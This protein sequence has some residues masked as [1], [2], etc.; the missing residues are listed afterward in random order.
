MAAG[1]DDGSKRRRAPAA[2]IALR[3]PFTVWLARVSITA[4]SPGRKLGAKTCSTEAQVLSPVSAPSSTTGATMRS[5]RR[6][7]TKVEVF[8]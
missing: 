2:S 3:T 7:A 8:R 6:P 4:V 5:A 1:R